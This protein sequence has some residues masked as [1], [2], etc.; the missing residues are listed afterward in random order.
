MGEKQAPGLQ[1]VA[2]LAELEGGNSHPGLQPPLL[3]VRGR[4]RGAPSPTLPLAPLAT[5]I[6]YSPVPEPRGSSW[7]PMSLSRL[8]RIGTSLQRGGGST[9]WPSCH[10]GHL[11]ILSFLVVDPS[12]L[13]G[14]GHL[15]ADRAVAPWAFLL[16]EPWALPRC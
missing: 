1:T 12:A 4:A 5:A 10:P 14:P 2:V 15:G 16:P 9:S 6:G 8:S 13:Q 3:L 7:E 11:L